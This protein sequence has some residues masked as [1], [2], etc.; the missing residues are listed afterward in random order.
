VELTN[1]TYTGQSTGKLNQVGTG[2][3]LVD[4]EELQNT[5]AITGTTGLT[6]S[7]SGSNLIVG[8]TITGNINLANAAGNSYVK[9][10]G[11][12]SYDHGTITMGSTSSG[13]GLH[14]QDINAALTLGS[15]STLQGYGY[16]TENS[17]GSNLHNNGLVN[18]N[19]S[20]QTLF[21]ALSNVTDNA[22]IEATNGGVLNFESANIFNNGAITANGGNVL[23]QSTN[24][25]GNA[26]S[27]LNQT[28]GV[29]LENGTHLNGIIDVTGS[30]GLTFSSSGSN[31]I[32]NGTITGN[33]NL[34]ETAQ[35]SYV[36]LINTNT[37]DHGTISLG[38]TSSGDGIHLQD[39]NASLAIGSNGVL[40]GYGWISQDS[41]GA[42]LTNSGLINANATGQTLTIGLTNLNNNA[43]IEATNG[44]IVNVAST[45]VNNDGAITADGGNVLLQS[46][47]YTG[48]VGSGLNQIAGQILENGTLLTG[49]I[50][51]TGTTGLTFSTS[52]S[53]VIRGGAV[54]GNLNLADSTQDSYV[55]FVGAN[56]YDHGTISIGSLSGGDG[57]HLQ[58]I[59]ATLT[60]GSSSTVEGYGYLNEDSG[61]SNL[62]NNGLIKG[63]TDG[64]SPNETMTIAI[65]NFTNNATTES[66]GGGV[67]NLA[68]THVNN[69]GAIT[70][71]GGSVLL[72]SNTYTGGV[73]SSLN[74]LSGLLEDN[75]TLLTGQVNVTGTTG[76]NFASNGSN[77]F[78]NANITGNLN[79]A[80]STQDA[81]VK[82]VGIN[83]Y[84]NGTISLGT[85][86]SG[87][88]VHIQDINASL[89]IGSQGVIQG[90]GDVRQDSGGSNVHNGGQIN[91]NSSGNTLTVAV[92]NFNNTGTAEATNGGTLNLASTNVG[93]SGTFYAQ[94]GATVDTTSYT[95]S[96]PVVAANSSVGQSFAVTPIL[97]QVDG[98][99]NIGSNGN[100]TATINAGTLEGTGTVNGSVNN[101][102]VKGGDSPGTL[103]INGNLIQGSAST[104]LEQIAGTP[105]SG[106]F[107]IVNVSGTA[108]LNGILNVELLNGFGPTIGQDFTFLTADNGVNGTF[109]SI[110]GPTGYTFGVNYFAND[111]VLT[112]DGVPATAPAPES[113]TMISF[114]LMLLAGLGCF[115][116]RSQR[117]RSQAV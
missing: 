106:L 112:V 80:T 105:G 24:Y 22:T 19:A 40:N 36:K 5:I 59:N 70:A 89:S 85:T 52:G 93:N 28:S 72:Q 57:I 30:T 110:D 41:G 11:A 21:L 87:N 18:A 12:N 76:L 53:N 13:N 37:Y 111:A 94:N 63:S 61:G 48:T 32:N 74:Q 49:T 78:S 65:T 27:T 108:N 46:G 34:A 43:T 115:T 114:G 17:G 71:N 102:G 9:L 8:G 100:G 29:L 47:T 39:I 1:G 33:L 91:A 82:F 79:L 75:G 92:T 116:Y 42:T 56:T 66:T 45:N 51:V 35:D 113:S 83:T 90:Y 38:E 97:T 62:I 103:T 14:L 60:L 6:F 88:G 98:T 55:K 23:L 81:Y 44:G 101:V 107:D 84:D 10:I 68:S 26:D 69:N 95:Q 109:S 104:F 16:V 54:S 4:G 67:L 20:G 99:M 50:D 73:G 31:T 86:S 117:A 2:E 3:L 77:V 64:V 15:D 25:T 96:A 7:T 58:D